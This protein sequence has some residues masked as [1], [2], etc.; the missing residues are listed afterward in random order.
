MSGSALT[1]SLVA[2][3]VIHLWGLTM[4]SL[5]WEW[6]GSPE[7][8]PNLIAADLVVITPPPPPSPVD[9]VTAT[10]LPP[11]PKPKEV[12]LPELPKE[13][14][15]PKIVVKRDFDFPPIAAD[16]PPLEGPAPRIALRVAL[17]NPALPRLQDVP[18][19]PPPLAEM[20]E[21][22]PP[23]PGPP[24]PLPDERPKGPPGNLLGPI[25]EGLE[26]VLPQSRGAVEGGEAGAGRLF[27]KGDLPVVPGPG[28][29]G[30][31]GGPGRAGLGLGRSGRGKSVAGIRPG[32]GG[33]GPGGGVGSPTRPLGGYQVK[34]RYPESARREGVQGITLLKLHVLESGKVGQILVERSAGHRD[35]DEAALEAVKKWRFEPARKGKRPTAV[36]VLLPVR[37]ELH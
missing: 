7:T 15:P 31:S 30:G 4:A 37:F 11:L 26:I 18:L 21:L 25:P 14:T 17:E 27:V 2:S 9:L 24:I 22:T 33:E 16:F 5:L 28:A 20:A 10:L 32:A 23:Q 13:I 34:P 35:L 29:G 36:W 19:G 3:M 12:K 6:G 8:P 1:S